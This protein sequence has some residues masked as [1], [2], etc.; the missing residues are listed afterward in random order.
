LP[1][2]KNFNDYV[3]RGRGRSEIITLDYSRGRRGVK[4]AKKLM[5]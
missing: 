1:V 2:K 5:T 3:I 4:I